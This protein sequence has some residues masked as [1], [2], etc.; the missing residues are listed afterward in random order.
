MSLFHFPWGICAL[1]IWISTDE[2]GSLGRRTLPRLIMRN[3]R[4]SQIFGSQCAHFC[5]KKRPRWNSWGFFF[6]NKTFSNRFFMEN[7]KLDHLTT[8]FE[9]HVCSLHFTFERHEGLIAV[10]DLRQR[11]FATTNCTASLLKARSNFL[12]PSAMFWTRIT[13]LFLFL[14]D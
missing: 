9:R 6:A 12:Y 10:G 1:F 3:E 7:R 11:F 5:P 2:L 14:W 4:S 13:A 8:V